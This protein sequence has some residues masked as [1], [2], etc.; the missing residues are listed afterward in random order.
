MVQLKDF[1]YFKPYFIFIEE[2]D[3]MLISY[4]N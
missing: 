3:N 1:Y 4:T 2:N